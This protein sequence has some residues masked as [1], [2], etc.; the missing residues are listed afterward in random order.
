MAAAGGSEAAP[1]GEG[2]AGALLEACLGDAAG[3]LLAVSGGPDSMALLGLAARWSG[4]PALA[5][6]TIDHG[7]RAAA[8]DEAAMVATACASLQVDH[9]TIRWEGDKPRGGLQAAARAARYA[10][11]AAEARRLGFTHVATAHHADDQ[12]ETVLMRLS[13]GSGLAGLAGMRLTTRR[14]GVVLARPFLGVDGRR[15]AATCA[16][17]EL[18]SVQDPSNAQLRFGRTRARAAL[19]ILAEQG[20][21]PSRLARLAV[22]AARADDALAAA[23]R[24]ALAAAG[25]TRNQERSTAA[26]PVLALEP[27]EIRLRALIELIHPPGGESAPQKLEKV[28]ALLRAI[29]EAA[30]CGVGLRRSV[31]SRIAD[32]RP[33]GRLMVS[34]APPRRRGTR[35]DR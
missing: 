27:E 3:V 12:A 10:L 24:T 8:A 18:P 11:L 14:E 13:A 29:D 16:S 35:L 17:M 32:L 5:A 15:L 9:R 2:E 1:I 7:L 6:A 31:G 34:D 26:W 22:R 28:E 33:D 19:A 20:L 21:T 23:A 25:A 4:R 30:A